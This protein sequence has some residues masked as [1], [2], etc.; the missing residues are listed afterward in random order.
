MLAFKV[1]PSGFL[2]ELSTEGF[3]ARV[4]LLDIQPAHRES[5]KAPGTIGVGGKICQSHHCLF[6]E[7]KTHTVTEQ[8]NVSPSAES[9]SQPVHYTK[10]PF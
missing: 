7:C 4:I 5:G 6:S 8:T 3:T 2:T 1:I 9:V 10:L